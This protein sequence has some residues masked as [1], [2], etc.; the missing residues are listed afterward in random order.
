M[1]VLTGIIQSIFFH[2]QCRPVDAEHGGS[3]ADWG[4]SGTRLWSLF[5]CHLPHVAKDRS[6]YPSG[7]ICF[8][9]NSSP[10]AHNRD[11]MMNRMSKFSSSVMSTMSS[12]LLW[13]DWVLMC[14]IRRL[15]MAEKHRDTSVSGLVTVRQWK[16]G[17]WWGH[18]LRGGKGEEFVPMSTLLSGNAVCKAGYPIFNRDIPLHQRFLVICRLGNSLNKSSTPVQKFTWTWQRLNEVSQLYMYCTLPKMESL[19]PLPLTLRSKYTD[20]SAHRTTATMH[21]SPSLPPCQAHCW[22][23]F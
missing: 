23:S 2:T 18:S 15:E 19:S 6:L 9:V 17:G 3:L 14:P 21:R 16:H 12:S 5:P 10:I 4:L 1:Q 8:M 13:Y 20:Q 22:L 11:S 7:V